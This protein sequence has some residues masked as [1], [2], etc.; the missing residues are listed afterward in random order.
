[1]NPRPY[2]GSQREASRQGTLTRP[3]G[4]EPDRVQNKP[5]SEA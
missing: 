5:E 3:E 4:Q 2:A 1:M